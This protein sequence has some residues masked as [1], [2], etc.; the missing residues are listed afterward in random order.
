MSRGPLLPTTPSLAPILPLDARKR[1][2]MRTLANGL[3]SANLLSGN[4]FRAKMTCGYVFPGRRGRKF[5]SSRPG[6]V[7]HSREAQTKVGEYRGESTARPSGAGVVRYA[8]R[9]SRGLLSTLHSALS[10]RRSTSGVDGQGL[11]PP[12]FLAAAWLSCQRRPACRESPRRF[13]T[14]NASLVVVSGSR[15]VLRRRAG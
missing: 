14:K 8:S 3:D 1:V 15:R 9:I 6:F 13:V 12:R 2:R 11:C 5:K 4:D 10:T 7:T